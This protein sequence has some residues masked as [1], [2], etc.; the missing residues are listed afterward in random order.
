[1]SGRAGGAVVP[2]LLSPPSSVPPT[3]STPASAAAVTHRGCI[4]HLSLLSARSTAQPRARVGG[5]NASGAGL[6]GEAASGLWPHHTR[7]HLSDP[8]RLAPA[9][10]GSA[11]FLRSPRGSQGLAPARGWGV[12]PLRSAGKAEPHLARLRGP[13]L[14][15]CLWS[16]W[17]GR[18]GQGRA[19]QER[20][21]RAL[22]RAPAGFEGVSASSALGVRV[23]RQREGSGG[24]PTRP[25]PRLTLV[26][27]AIR[28]LPSDSTCSLTRASSESTLEMRLLN[29]LR[30][31]R[32]SSESSPS[33]ASMLLKDRSGGRGPRGPGLVQ[34]DCPETDPRPLRLGCPPS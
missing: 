15:R 30:S 4:A 17:G 24:P 33:M 34:G 2:K 1:M 29:R 22:R 5:V 20:P 10:P 16:E 28:L 21:T 13:H 3:P 9:V 32:F 19:P 12:E 27:F 11:S 26:R 7:R 8:C 6:G 31:S 25:A 23:S 14:R 18:A